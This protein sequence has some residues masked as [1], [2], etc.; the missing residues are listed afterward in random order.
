MEIVYTKETSTS[1]HDIDEKIQ[2]AAQNNMFG[3][4]NVTDLQGKMK[5]KGIEFA[6]ACK[7]FDVCN[8]SRAKAVLSVDMV[9]STV[10]PCRISVYEEDGVT[11]LSTLLPTKVIGMFGA[12]GL[13]EDAQFVEAALKAIVDEAA[14]A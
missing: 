6:K 9:I 14:T 4:L 12:E 3:V 7:V 8:P 11:K 2:T 10:L 5:A 13:E 1:V